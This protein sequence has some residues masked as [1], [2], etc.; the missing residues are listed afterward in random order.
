MAFDPQLSPNAVLNILLD[1]A[2]PQTD[3]VRSKGADE[4]A[5]HL[6]TL[7]VRDAQ[8]LDALRAEVAQLRTVTKWPVI[9]TR[10]LGFMRAQK[11]SLV[12]MDKYEVE[13]IGHALDLCEKADNDIFK[14]LPRAMDKAGI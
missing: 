12:E 11:S 4:A 6:R 7:L 1:R 9:L 8:E 10:I 14:A 5:A 13:M 2:I 3:K